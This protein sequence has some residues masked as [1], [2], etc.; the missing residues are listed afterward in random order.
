MGS[1]VKNAALQRIATLVAMT[2]VVLLGNNEATASAL[3]ALTTSN[4]TAL[5]LSTLDTNDANYDH[6]S[7]ADANVIF[8]KIAN[9]AA[10][11]RYKPSRSCRRG[12][13]YTF[14]LPG[15]G[16]DKIPQRCVYKENRN[17]N[18]RG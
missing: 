7:L 9:A 14:C 6:L 18:C 3:S 15:E 11:R 12:R 1:N 16:R 17:R 13:P 8:L 5:A 2:M 10:R 4:T